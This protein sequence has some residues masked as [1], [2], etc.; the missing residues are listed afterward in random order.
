M[1]QAALAFII[2]F[3]S[4]LNDPEYSIEGIEDDGIHAEEPRW[5]S[6]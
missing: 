6:G 4:F 5:K 1:V 2:I 3:Q